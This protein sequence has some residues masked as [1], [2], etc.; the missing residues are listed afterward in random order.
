M[1]NPPNDPYGQNPYGQDPYGQPNPYGQQPPGQYGA[2][3]YAA[4]PYG[5][6]G[7]YGA[8]QPPQ[9]AAGGGQFPPPPPPKKPS[10][11]WW[12][13]GGGLLVIAAVV[14][15]VVGLTVDW[16]S[17][18]SSS[19]AS[20]S[21][22]TQPSTGSTDQSTPANP[23]SALQTATACTPNASSGT[24]PS[25][26]AAAGPLSFP[27]SAAPGWTPYADASMP[28]SISMVG[29][30]NDLPDA[31][32]MMQVEVGI[33]N[34]VPTMSVADQATKLI[35][36]IAQGPGYNQA[37]PVLGPVTSTNIMVDGVPAVQSD[38]N[39]TVTGRPVP[40]DSVRI[41]VV[42]TN[43]V[44]YFFGAT[45][46]GDTAN[47]AVVEGVQGALKVSNS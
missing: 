47:R 31:R 34:F 11:T 36:C 44:T 30:I 27:L 24:T 23:N 16:S 26:T 6:T 15:L 1:T 25:G 9:F 22:S 17:S 10:T 20:S 5:T 37:Q 38:A 40:G 19:A 18:S 4:D 35:N 33:T 41:V 21:T 32:W 14:A 39:V 42:A 28:N 45:P 12:W 29:A 13:V 7:A 43:P 3:P 2:D 46:I 8:Q